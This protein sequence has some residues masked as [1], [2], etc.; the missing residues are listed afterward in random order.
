MFILVVGEDDPDDER[1]SKA[2][3]ATSVKRM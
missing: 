2:Q 1:R 3:T